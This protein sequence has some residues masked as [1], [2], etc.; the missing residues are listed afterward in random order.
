MSK[1]TWGAQDHDTLVMA[2]T[3]TRLWDKC[4]GSLLIFGRQHICY[5]WCIQGTLTHA[6]QRIWTRNVWYSSA[7]A[8]TG[9]HQAQVDDS[10]SRKPQARDVMAIENAPLKG[11]GLHTYECSMLSTWAS[12]SSA[13]DVNGFLMVRDDVTPA[14]RAGFANQTW[15][16]KLWGREPAC[17]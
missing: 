16:L 7:P 3:L 8:Y 6:S 4:V 15:L 17:S 9:M 5:A 10:N 11:L 14:R 2:E 1:V 12:T 13:S